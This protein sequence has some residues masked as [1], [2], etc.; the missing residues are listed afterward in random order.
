[1]VQVE[2]PTTGCPAVG[3]FLMVTHNGNSGAS[4]LRA[5]IDEANDTAGD[6]TID[7]DPAFAW[8]TLGNEIVLASSLP[9]I[10][11]ATGKTVIQ[12]TP[13]KEVTVDG[14]SGSFHCFTIQSA[15]NEIR[16]LTIVRCVNPLATFY[17]GILITGAGATGNTIAGN[18]IGTNS[19]SAAALGNY[20]GVE[21]SSSAA[22]NTVGGTT[23]G[24]RNII[25]GNTGNGVWITGA[26]TD[27]NTVTGNYIGTD[28]SGAVAIGNVN[29]VG[30][31]L[32]AK[33]NTIG[34]TNNP[35]PGCAGE[36]NLIS[37]NSETG[38]GISGVGTDGNKV[39]GN[40]IGTDV[41]GAVA[42]GNK[43]GVNIT[44]SATNNT[45]GGTTTSE[46]NIISGNSVYGVVVS[47][48]GTDGN[49]ILGNYI[50]TNEAGDGA[51]PNTSGIAVLNDA[52]NTVIGGAGLNAGN[53]ISGNVVGISVND[54]DGTEIKGN[55]IGTRPDGETALANTS[56]AIQLT[57]GAQ[58]TIIGGTG[59]AN[60]IANSGF[61]GAGVALTGALT[62][63][64]KISGNSIYTNAGKGISLGAGSN[65]NRGRPK[66]ICASDRGGGVIQ[67]EGEKCD[68]CV[69]NDCVVELFRADNDG[70][71]GPVVIADAAGE[72][73]EYLDQYTTLGVNTFSLTV[74]MSGGVEISATAIDSS[75][76]TSEFAVNMDTTPASPTVGAV[77]FTPDEIK[78]DGSESTIITAVVTDPNGACDIKSV[79]VDLTLLGGSA[80]A[81]LYDDGTNGDAVAGDG[82]FTLG[83]ITATAPP[84]P[85]N[86]GTYTFTVTAEDYSGNTDTGQDD[87]TINTGPTV[88]NV[89]FNPN[90]G[91]NGGTVT[92][93]AEVTDDNGVPGD[94]ST[95]TI[96][97]TP[98]GGAAAKAMAN[99]G[100]CA[101]PSVT[102]RKYSTS[103][104]VSHGGPFPAAEN[105]TVTATDTK[106]QT[107]SDS[108]T[109]QIV[110]VA[111][112]PPTLN[113]AT[114]NAGAID[115]KWRSPLKYTS[116]ATIMDPLQGHYIYRRT[117]SGSY[118]AALA[119]DG[120]STA[121][122]TVYIYND[123]SVTA[124]ETYCYKVTAVSGTGIESAMSNERCETALPDPYVFK[125]ACGNVDP[126]HYYPPATPGM[127]NR[128][129]DVAADGA[130]FIYVADTDNN[131]IQKFT[132]DCGYVWHWGE[133]GNANGEFKS[134]KGIA[135]AGGEVFVVD[136]YDRVQVFS[137]GGVYRRS[138][139][140]QMPI[141]IEYDELSGYLYVSIELDWIF[142][143]QTDGT[144]VTKWKMIGGKQLDFDSAG[145]LYY[146]Q[147]YVSMVKVLDSGG[148]AAGEWGS[149]G[150][151]YGELDYPLGIAV[152]GA[153][154]VY[155]S[156]VLNSRVQ[157]FDTSGTL[158]NVIP[159]S[160][161]EY[162]AM[163]NPSGMSV[164]SWL[165]GKTRLF[166]LDRNSS[167]LLVFEE[168]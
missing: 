143:Y 58:N 141:D 85:P 139:T 144:Y 136:D 158:K 79:T 81:D 3:G 25:S 31:S 96:D 74:T 120:L 159:N 142:V 52:Q 56:D 11:D 99:S 157:I 78:G 84:N 37:G 32:P 166:L 70:T 167:R 72:G 154:R 90:P 33:N 116:G 150:S 103:F 101:V 165:T 17:S 48:T 88:S 93:Y 126:V 82:T 1:N 123:S 148:A 160:G 111:P 91:G 86:G 60:T 51:L 124:F 76:N 16:G 47:D 127:F 55:L 34:G 45:V 106:N 156:E 122:N 8:D 29:G 18:Y 162:F 161:P 65:N 69:C 57:N 43:Y 21:I 153:D 9:T 62:D 10:N 149:R 95:V 132:E 104:T 117:S 140:V 87:L 68:G 164:S 135:Y 155:V 77:T 59:A 35:G 131:R 27:G 71:T 105:L 53:V 128:P 80:T 119:F 112:N 54:A 20:F 133:L 168:P 66:F 100:A 129:M 49:E 73:Y 75:N 94:I 7:F 109:L 42:I 64:N 14:N 19:A 41:S 125:T 5:C 83:G 67:V 115:V 2:L 118:G 61:G 152:D 39:I 138:W 145:N 137:T 108:G 44:M 147:P 121:T 22:N 130:G 38:V 107:G 28:V 12:N 97:L 92:V 110:D 163:Q 40:Y 134:P 6:Q 23:S 26:G 98:V 113:S 63:F 13:L 89:T 146:S 46:R 36:C 15:N 114:N 50:G 151:G 4:S 30:I 102:C 24:E